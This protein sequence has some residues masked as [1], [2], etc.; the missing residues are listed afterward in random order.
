MKNKAAS[1]CVRIDILFVPTIWAR[2]RLSE[3]QNSQAKFQ[4]SGSQRRLLWIFRLRFEFPWSE[5]LVNKDVKD[6]LANFTCMKVFLF[7]FLELV[8]S[9]RRLQ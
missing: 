7:P 5:W 9:S 1:L 3:G 6:T 8:P 4:P 2:S